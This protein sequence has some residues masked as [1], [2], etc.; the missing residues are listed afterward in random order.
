MNLFERCIFIKHES[1]ENGDGQ[2]P[3]IQTQTTNHMPALNEKFHRNVPGPFYVDLSCTDCGLCPEIAPS[4]FR[5]A[6][7]EGQSFVWQQPMSPEAV[8]QAEEAMNSCPTESIG[9]DGREEQ[10]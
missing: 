2:R 8:A 5:R 1:T 3:L 6:D 10:D 9:Q 4:V 7:E